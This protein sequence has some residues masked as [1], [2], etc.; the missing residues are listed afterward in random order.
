MI[1][2]FGIAKA[3]IGCSNADAIRQPYARSS[4]ARAGYKARKS[5]V[6]AGACVELSEIGKFPE[7]WICL[8]PLKG[9]SSE[10]VGYPTQKP[11]SLLER[12]IKASSNEGDFVLD[13]F[14]GCATTCIASENLNRQWAGIDISK[15]AFELV[16]QRS[17][18]EVLKKS[19]TTEMHFMNPADEVIYRED[20]CRVP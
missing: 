9:N 10:Y 11:L 19:K 16:K 1:L 20:I 7:S 15:K 14:C 17:D 5:K 3:I 6:T 8:P 12:V 2:F 4:T 18:R 13:P